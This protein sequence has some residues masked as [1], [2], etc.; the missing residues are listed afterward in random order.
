MDLVSLQSFYNL[1][2]L[3][4]SLSFP[5]LPTLASE[6][7][8]ICPRTG[9]PLTFAELKTRAEMDVHYNIS[10]YLKVTKHVI[11]LLNKSVLPS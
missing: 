5:R 9:S 6:K 7:G 4:F 10:K 1:E 8:V 2:R 3:V 11:V